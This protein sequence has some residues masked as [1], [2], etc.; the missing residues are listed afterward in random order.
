MADLMFTK[1][2]IDGKSYVIPEA[3]TSQKGLM[4]PEMVTK[5]NGQLTEAQV[6]NKVDTAINTFA[7]KVTDDN[8]TLDTFK[9]IVDYVA[10]NKEGWAD[11]VSDVSQLKTDVAAF[12]YSYD[13]STQTLTLGGFKP[14]A[15]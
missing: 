8:T 11:V 2:V 9:E 4:T 12:N 5:L 15:A 10:E 14:A 3:S 1:L 13:A 6:Q 7:T